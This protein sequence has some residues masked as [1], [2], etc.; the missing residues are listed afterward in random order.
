[1]LVHE[2]KVS[3]YDNLHVLF[4]DIIA[5]PQIPKEFGG[6]FTRRSSALA[7]PGDDK[8]NAMSKHFVL[9]SRIYAA[10]GFL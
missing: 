10:E 7:E 8:I 3:Q 2:K 4:V 9:A 6:G 5:H 1:M